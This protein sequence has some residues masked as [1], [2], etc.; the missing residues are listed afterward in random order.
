MWL[1]R[2]PYRTRSLSNLLL[3]GSAIVSREALGRAVPIVQ[4]AR[5]VRDTRH[6]TIIRSVGWVAV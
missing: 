2:L 1:I 4:S 3:S 6:Q 5:V